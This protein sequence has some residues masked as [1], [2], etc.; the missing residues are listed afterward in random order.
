MKK[1]FPFIR[2]VKL[3][4]AAM[5]APVMFN[6]SLGQLPEGIRKE[7][8]IKQALCY[9]WN[10]NYKVGFTTALEE[11]TESVSTID[12]LGNGSLMINTTS[13]KVASWSYDK[14]SHLLILDLKGRTESY[15][16]LKLTNKELLLQAVDSGET[17]IR[18]WRND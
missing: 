8:D 11:P 1:Q 12:F 13:P 7:K 3:I 14:K 15:K 9:T 18:Y 2:R 6:V 17:Q 16:I 5:F 4:M 10:L